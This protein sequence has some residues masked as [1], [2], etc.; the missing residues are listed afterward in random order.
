MNPQEILAA[1][2]Q[3]PARCSDFVAWRAGWRSSGDPVRD[4]LQGGL[5]AGNLA[6]AFAAGYQAALRLLLP[7]RLPDDAFAALLLSEGRRQRPEELATQL[8]AH[9]DGYLLNGEKSF[10]TGGGHADLLLVVARCDVRGAADGAGGAAARV[11]AV[12]VMLPRAT[13]G[14]TLEARADVP[15]LHELPHAR[16]RLVDVPV[17][18]AQVLP[19]DGWRD[20]GKPFRSCEDICVSLSFAAYLFA[21]GR[22]EGWPETLLASLAGCVLRLA[23]LAGM[24]PG[25]VYTHILLGAAEQELAAAAVQVDACIGGSET[26]FARDWRAN[27]AFLLLAAPARAKRLHNAI[28]TLFPGRPDSA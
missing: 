19:G 24:P 16:A 2:A 13:P 27:R 6:L 21:Q 14:V 10:V 12:L 17:T 3:S 5:A 11:P 20:Y 1:L 7:A 23:D 25:D 9:A 18:A 22:T 28:A 26:P 15:V 8:R 4:A